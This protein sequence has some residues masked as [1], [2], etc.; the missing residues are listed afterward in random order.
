MMIV[1]HEYQIKFH[2]IKI[3]SKTISIKVGWLVPA[4]ECVKQNNIFLL[5]ALRVSV[6]IEKC[7]A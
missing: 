7:L 6:E 4:L 3:R 1:L 2:E 5:M